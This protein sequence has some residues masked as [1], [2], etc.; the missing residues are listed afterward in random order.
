MEWTSQSVR[1][2]E[3]SGST[4]NRFRIASLPENCY[5]IYVELIIVSGE[6][7]RSL[8]ALHTE[9]RERA[10]DRQI[11]FGFGNPDRPPVMIVT[12]SPSHFDAVSGLEPGLSPERYRQICHVECWNEL[13]EQG[14][15]KSYIA[16]LFLRSG[17][18]TGTWDIPPGRW[19]DVL[20]ATSVYK[21][22]AERSA[23]PGVVDERYLDRLESEIRLVDPAVIVTAGDVA[24]RSVAEALLGDDAP[25]IVD[26]TDY[27]S[28]KPSTYETDPPMLPT[29]HWSAP[30]RE[31][32]Y[33]YRF[34]ESVTTARNHLQPYLEEH[35]AYRE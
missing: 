19:M 22:T 23:I 17:V 20:Y 34:N 31:S 2:I 14:L 29:M 1:V 18:T 4:P 26:L 28:W 8:E 13:I 25:R 9:L 10:G 7:F 12:G 33:R 15:F 16:R 5:T 35:E 6:K 24:T 3:R 21:T 30:K 32:T 11:H 27:P